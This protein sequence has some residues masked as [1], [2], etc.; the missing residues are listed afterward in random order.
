MAKRSRRWPEG[1]RTKGRETEHEGV[2]P[3]GTCSHL[4]P[5]G[6]VETLHL[7]VFLRLSKGTV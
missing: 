6:N 4:V 2:C 5:S 7:I 1:E 3:L